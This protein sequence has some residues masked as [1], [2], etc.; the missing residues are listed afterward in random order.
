MTDAISLGSK[1]G[2]LFWLTLGLVVSLHQVARAGA[3]SAHH[4]AE[5]GLG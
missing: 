1:V 4:V 3:P 5:T 2:V